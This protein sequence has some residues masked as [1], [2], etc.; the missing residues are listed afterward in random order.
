MAAGE[1]ALVALAIRGDVLLVLLPELLDRGDDG[2]VAALKYSQKQK[3]HNIGKR[4]EEG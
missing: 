2:W 4:R 1:A 3:T